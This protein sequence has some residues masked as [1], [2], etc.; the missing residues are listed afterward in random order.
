MK[1]ISKK[2]SLFLCICLL[3]NSCS[4]KL[5]SPD[6]L[7][8][9]KTQKLQEYDYTKF[10][11]KN[12]LEEIKSLNKKLINFDKS[13]TIEE[14][15]KLGK[16]FSAVIE[17]YKIFKALEFTRKDISFSVQPNSKMTFKFN[18]YCLNSGKASPRQN[19]QFVLRKN[20]PD[21]PLYKDIV[22]YT[23]S[24]KKIKPV[25]KQL[26]FWNL[27]ND[28]KFENLPQDQQAFLTDIDPMAYLKVNNM[29]KSEVSAQLTKYAKAN[30]PFY[31]DTKKTIDL[32]KGKAY[33]YQD[34]ANK[35][36]KLASKLKLL[37]DEGPIKADGYDIYTL[38]QSSGF[39]GTTITFINITSLLHVISCAAFLDP[40]NNNVQ[41]I[42][43]DMPS[44][45]E[46]YEKYKNSHS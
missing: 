8:S 18:S 9:E 23:N 37:P 24:G 17:Q 40:L 34:Y 4:T 44:I 41:P 6:R 26:L 10:S 3:L 46:E 33:T 1:K 13:Q 27:K 12:F 25:N 28:V 11:H 31:N 15:E 29:I 7:L 43:L 22:L 14:C 38:T 35:V 21:I 36:E 20:S 5:I 42:G 39:S 30:I 2:F 32:V 16:E 45:L 19:E